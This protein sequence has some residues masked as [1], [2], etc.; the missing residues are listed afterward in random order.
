MTTSFNSSALLGFAPQLVGNSH[1]SSEPALKCIPLSFVPGKRVFSSSGLI[2]EPKQ[3]SCGA[4]DANSAHVVSKLDNLVN[5]LRAEQRKAGVAPPIS[6]EP[7]LSDSLLSLS[8]PR[9][10]SSSS[11]ESRARVL[12]VLGRASEIIKSVDAE[13]VGVSSAPILHN[14]NADTRTSRSHF[15]RRRGGVSN[16]CDIFIFTSEHEDKEQEQEEPQIS[17]SSQSGRIVDVREPQHETSSMGLE[18]RNRSRRPSRILS[19]NY[20]AGQ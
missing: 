7:S 4:K 8:R 15:V 12:N 13:S 20:S 17:A 16:L 14:K 18:R 3:L 9:T 6:S 10:R 2:F 11:A 5:S 1:D 19:H